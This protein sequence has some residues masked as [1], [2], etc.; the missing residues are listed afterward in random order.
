MKKFAIGA[1]TKEMF[2]QEM[3]KRK[4]LPLQ[5]DKSAGPHGLEHCAETLEKSLSEIFL[6]PFKAGEL[7]VALEDC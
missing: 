4:L 5:V 6:K 7:L 1:L 2:S 3:A